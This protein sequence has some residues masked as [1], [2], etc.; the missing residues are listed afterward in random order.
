MLWLFFWKDFWFSKPVKIKRLNARY[1]GVDEKKD[2][3]ISIYI[4][5]FKDTQENPSKF[6]IFIYEFYIGY[7]PI[8]S[9]AVS[10][11]KF[12]MFWQ[13]YDNFASMKFI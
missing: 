9:F 2:L 7:L 8:Y 12:W 5:L 3:N 1:S 6:R 13:V 10:R 11:Y 4:P